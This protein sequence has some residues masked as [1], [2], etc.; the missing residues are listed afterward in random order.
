[1]AV[2]ATVCSGLGQGRGRPRSSPFQGMPCWARGLGRHRLGV[3]G[4]LDPRAVAVGVDLGELR[5]EEEDLRRVVNPDQEHHERARRPV[6]RAEAAPAQVQADEALADQEQD[7]RQHRADP[8]V[9]P[10]DL[11]IR[12]EL[13]DQREEEG[14]DGE[15]DEDVRHLEHRPEAGGQAAREREERRQRPR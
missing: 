12:Q 8:D 5:P 2:R 3:R 11:R 13:E 15:R 10:G 7:R 1:M 6:G 4:G 14:D 9:P